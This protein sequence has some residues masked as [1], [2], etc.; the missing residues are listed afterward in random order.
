MTP[1]TMLAPILA[2]TQRRVASLPP[3]P[4]LRAEARDLPQPRDFAAALGDPGL[5]VIAEIKR[6]SPSAG[7]LAPEL[8]P[9]SQARA[10]VAGGAA[11]IS[12]LTEPDFF[13]G[14]LDDLAVVRR[15]VAVPLLRKDFTLDPRQIW[16][17]RLA[18][19]DAV[20][21]IVAAVGNR[22][23]ELLASAAEAGVAALVEVHA[24]EEVA[25]AIG[26]GAAIVGVNNRDLTTFQ[27]DLGVAERAAP[28]LPEEVVTVAESGVSD[29]A[30]AQ[31]MAAAGYDAILVGEA[32]VRSAEPAQLLASLRNG[33]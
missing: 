27:T 14:S 19:A 1:A 2:A 8:D 20:L 30:A 13:A 26:A 7:P 17:A 6:R 3:V 15:V 10:Y 33:P 25:L 5:Q 16:E 18:G 29:P 32:L 28:L 21:L 24:D 4:E 9:A 31:R 12:V 22:L 23:G 11:A